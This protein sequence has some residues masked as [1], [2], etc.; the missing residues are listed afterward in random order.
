ML[1][2]AISHI[3][4]KTYLKLFLTGVERRLQNIKNAKLHKEIQAHD[5]S[6]EFNL[7][8]LVRSNYLIMQNSIEGV[9]AIINE[10]LIQ[11]I[12]ICNGFLLHN[13]VTSKCIYHLIDTFATSQY[14]STW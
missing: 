14:K 5:T 9:N 1:C 11:Y 3:N 2:F 6:L 8:T 13:T 7:L 10:N 12:Y 4:D